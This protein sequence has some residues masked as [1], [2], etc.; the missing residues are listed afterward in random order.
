ME[1]YYVVDVYV[2]RQYTSLLPV[3]SNKI[4]QLVI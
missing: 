4:I 1:K 3:T 2:D